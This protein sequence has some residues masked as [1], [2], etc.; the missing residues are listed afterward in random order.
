MHE[1]V[2]DKN[3]KRGKGLRSAPMGK[4]KV[5]PV[6][7]RAWGVVGLKT[8]KGS[9]SPGPVQRTQSRPATVSPQQY[10]RA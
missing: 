6:R 10:A 4:D 7:A 1:Q 3:R 9:Q 8:I 2:N 5:R